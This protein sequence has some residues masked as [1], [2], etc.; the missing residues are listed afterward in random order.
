MRL[1]TSFQA[2][3]FYTYF[4]GTNVNK[5]YCFKLSENLKNVAN[6]KLVARRREK[7]NGFSRHGPH[8]EPVLVL[9]TPGFCER[10]VR[11]V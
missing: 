8:A 10:Y 11:I 1:L 2:L 4:I 5:R 9:G 7:P 3:D 6:C